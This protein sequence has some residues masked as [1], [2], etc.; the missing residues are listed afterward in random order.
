MSVTRHY[1]C[2]YCNHHATL[3]EEDVDYI[4]DHEDFTIQKPAEGHKRLSWYYVV[5][6]NPECRKFSLRVFL[7][8][9]EFDNARREFYPKGAPKKWRLVPPSQAK[10]FPDYIPK[11]ILDDYREA[12]M[13][14]DLSPKASATLARRCLQGILRDFW[15]VKP[16]KLANEIDQIKDKTDPLTWDAITAVRKIG[17]IGAHMEEDIN[18]IIDVD[19]N[20]AG[21][22][23]SLIEILLKDWYVAREERRKQLTEIKQIAAQKGEAKK[24]DS[25][26]ETESEDVETPPDTRPID[27]I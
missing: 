17:N 12:C 10:V 1:L 5:C 22:L 4:L 24:E 11:A 8:N 7:H 27:P 16:G 14:V 13:I 21:K 3:R 6:P 15:E 18:L 26:E 19:P 9:G 2:P 25:T 20:E 23:I